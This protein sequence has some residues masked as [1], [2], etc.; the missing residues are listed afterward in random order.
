MSSLNWISRRKTS[1][2]D[3]FFGSDVDNFSR[4]FQLEEDRS[5]LY[6]QF[7]QI[8]GRETQ[9]IASYSPGRVF[10]AAWRLVGSVLVYGYMLPNVWA[11][12]S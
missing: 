10:A 7:R 5:R 12:R 9:S 8:G 1:R 6:L 3:A 4:P 2:P 11:G